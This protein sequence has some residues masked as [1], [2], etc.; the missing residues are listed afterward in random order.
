MNLL[1]NKE[2]QQLPLNTE[3]VPSQRVAFDLG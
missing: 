2:D 1:A 3:H